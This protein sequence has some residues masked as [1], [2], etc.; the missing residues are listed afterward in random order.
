M[1]KVERKAKGTKN[2]IR[3]SELDPKFKYE[4]ASQPG[5]EKL[6]VCYACGVCTAG[7]PVSE[8]SEDFDP[9]KIVRMVLMGMKERVL[10]SDFI[11]Y[12]TQCFTCS[13]HCPQNVKFTDIM[14]VLRDMA[15]KEGF[16][17]S[18]FL[19]KAKELDRFSQKV[20]FRLM[21]SIVAKKGKSFTLNPGE[22]L[23]RVAKELA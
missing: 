11:W 8:V 12:C 21:K 5:G 14:R 10:S 22:L 3:S 20:R 15:V 17:D 13:G 6:K 7:C 2:V 19:Q 16:V 1:A 18:S 4:V 23:G 9:R